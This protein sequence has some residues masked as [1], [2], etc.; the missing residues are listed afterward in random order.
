MAYTGKVDVDRG[1]MCCIHRSGMTVWMYLDDPG[2][3][4]DDHLALVPDAVAKEAGFNV[5]RNRKLRIR[6]EELKR[7]RAVMDEKLQI[8]STTQIMAESGR[9]RLE[10]Y[11]NGMARVVTDDGP[12]FSTPMT[13]SIAEAL[14]KSLTENPVAGTEGEKE[15]EQK[16]AAADGKPSVSSSTPAPTGVGAKR[17]AP[18]KA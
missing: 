3:Y 8:D 14:F 17:P 13:F 9:Y 1:A 2:V 18:M 11:E 15:P 5:E 12:L 4:F 10:Q 7:V 16:E 6:N